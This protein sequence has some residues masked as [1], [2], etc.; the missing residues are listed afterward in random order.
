MVAI[1]QIKL[2]DP[3]VPAALF[4]LLQRDEALA[5]LREGDGI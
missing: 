4:R 2:V 1:D 3:S 5:Y